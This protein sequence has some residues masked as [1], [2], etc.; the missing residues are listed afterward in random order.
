VKEKELSP[1]LDGNESE[2][3]NATEWQKKHEEFLERHELF[4][5]YISL[6]PKDIFYVPD[7]LIDVNGYPILMNL[8][9]LYAFLWK[10]YNIFFTLEGIWAINP[11]TVMSTLGEL[12]K[13]SEWRDRILLK[14]QKEWE[15]ARKEYNESLNEEEVDESSDIK[16]LM[17]RKRLNK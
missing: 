6:I 16:V 4:K 13:H 17:E 12:W 2:K 5:P 14:E 10:N 1:S 3:S 15:K 8:P 11:V 9:E 7:E